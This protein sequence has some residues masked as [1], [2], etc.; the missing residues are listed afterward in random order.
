MGIHESQS[1]FYENL[2]ALARLHG[3]RVPEALE[4]FPELSGHTAEEFYRSQ[5]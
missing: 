2:L 5:Q 3:L 4:L 1:R